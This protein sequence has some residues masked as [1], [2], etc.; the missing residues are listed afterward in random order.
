VTAPALVFG[1]NGGETL[2]AGGGPAVLVGGS[3]H[4]KL[5]GGLAPTIMIGGASHDELKGASGRDLMISGST[6]LDANLTAL[7][8]ILAEW[9][10]TDAIYAT[11]VAHL[12]GATPGGLNAPYFLDAGTLID[13][14]RRDEL[15]GASGGSN[16]YVARVTG[17]K[18]D[19]I[20]GLNSGE[21]VLN[22]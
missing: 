18:R 7:R 13:D 10:R 12:T 3:G 17:A 8:A 6:T 16:L 5:E 21:I 20:V 2:H 9:T 19:V 11:K 4:D 14:D 15:E 22:P 1:G